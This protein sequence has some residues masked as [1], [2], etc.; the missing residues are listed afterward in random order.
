[1]NPAEITDEELVEFIDQRK[2]QK[3]VVDVLKSIG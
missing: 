3:F 1:M 2:R